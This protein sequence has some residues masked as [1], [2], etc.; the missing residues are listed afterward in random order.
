[1][2][3]TMPSTARTSRSALG[4]RSRSLD[5]TSTDHHGDPPVKLPSIVAGPRTTLKAVATCPT[6]LS[7]QMLPRPDDACVCID[8][9]PC[10]QTR[11]TPRQLL[12]KRH[13]TGDITSRTNNVHRQ[14]LVSD[15]LRRPQTARQRVTLQRSDALAGDSEALSEVDDCEVVDDESIDKCRRW[16]RTL[17]G[18]FSGLCR[19]LSVPDSSPGYDDVTFTTYV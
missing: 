17:P 1:M 14:Q 19:V 7:V 15:R 5:D 10:Q 11:Q 18:K 8:N 3:R 6:K 16:L 13:S 4:T 2:T 9:G 12:E